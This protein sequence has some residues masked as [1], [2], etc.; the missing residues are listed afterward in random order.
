MNI[1]RYEPI[2]NGVRRPGVLRGLKVHLVILTMLFSWYS[3]VYVHTIISWFIYLFI[4]F[5]Y[6]FQTYLQIFSQ[7]WCF[8]CEFLIKTL[9]HTPTYTH[10]S[11]TVSIPAI[12]AGDKIRKYWTTFLCNKNSISPFK[13]YI[14]LLF[15]VFGTLEL[16]WLKLSIW[17]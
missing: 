6:L 16:V 1:A 13:F 15:L 8:I 11:N 14:P 9:T 5:I 7:F 10:N 12:L 2:R 17:K 4:Y 3:S